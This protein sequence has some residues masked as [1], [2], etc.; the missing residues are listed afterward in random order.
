MLRRRLAFC[1]ALLLACLPGGVGAAGSSG[2]FSLDREAV[3]LRLATRDLRVEAPGFGGGLRRG[4]PAAERALRSPELRSRVAEVDLGQLEAARLDA[5]GR[6]PHRLNLNLFADAEFEAEFERSAATAS[7]Y[8]LTGRL[9][10]QPLSTVVLA[11]NGDWVAGT[12][13]SSGGRYAVRPLGGGVA[14]VRQL[15][16]SA[17][18]RC[19]VGAE[20]A[21]GSTGRPPPETSPPSGSALPKSAPLSEAFPEDDGSVID[22]LVVYPSFAR[23]SVG[24]HLAM[25]ARIDSDVALTNEIYRASGAVQRLNLVGAV[26]L[27]RRPGEGADRVMPDILDRLVDGSDG[28]MDEAHALRDAYAADMVLLHWGHLTGLG[29]GL[30][31]GGVSGVAFQMEDLSGGYERLAFSVANSF[32]FA[33]ELGHGMGLR[34]HRADDA[35]NTPFPY[36]HGHVVPD[37]SPGLPPERE[38]RGMFTIMAS[39]GSDLYD[40]PRFSNPN[41]RYP[42]GSGAVIGVPGDAPS[43]SADGP[44]DAVRS[45]NGTRRVVANFRR[46]A[47]RC[48]YELSAPEGELPASG[49]EFRIGVR[50]GTGCA[51]SAWSNDDFVSV[52]EGA[53]GVGDGEVVFGVSANGGW[54]REAAVFVAGEAYLAEQATAK[55]RRAP[56]PVCDRIP[57][58]RAAITEAAGKEACGEVAASDLASIRVLDLSR[59][60]WCMSAICTIEQEMRTALPMGSLDGLTGLVSLDLTIGHRLKALAPGL[61]DGLVRLARLD[62]SDNKLEALESGVFEGVPNLAYLNLDENWSLETIEP[63][64]FRGLANVD[65]LHLEEVGLTELREGAFEG[66]TNLRFLTVWDAAVAKTE[67]GAFDGLTNLQSL[68]LE[69]VGEAAEL[70]LGLFN[71]LDNLRYL[72]VGG[73]GGVAELPSGLFDGLD[74][75][76]WLALESF[77]GVGELPSGLFNGLDRLET[78]YLIDNHFETL[79]LGA[80]DGLSALT[81]LFLRNNDLQSLEPGVFSGL[82]ALETLFLD[83]NQLRSLDPD[84]FEG[85]SRLDWLNLSDNQFATLHPSLFRGLGNLTVLDLDGNK[86]ST[87]D[88]GLFDGQRDEY[89]R[90][91]MFRMNLSRNRLTRLE[92]GLLRGMEQLEYLELQDN[93]LAALPPRMFEGLYSLV[94]LDLSGNP[95]APFVFRPELVQVEGAAD[96]DGAAEVALELPQGAAFDL[97]VGLSASGGAL[98]ADEAGVLIGQT[99]GGTVAVRPDGAGSVAVRMTGV[100]EVPG[101]PCTEPVA[102]SRSSS[103]PCLKGVRT[104]LGASLVLRDFVLH[105]LSNQALAPGGAVRFDLGSA[106]PDFPDGTTYAVGVDAPAVAEA[107]LAE[108][109]LTVA[110][111]GRGAT[112]VSVTATAPDGRREVRSFTVAV[113]QAANSYWSG[114]RS[115]LLK[116]PSSVESDG[117]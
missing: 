52:A 86:L 10:D 117:S 83:G 47:V 109:L 33:H 18:G 43:D 59:A 78:L 65:E 110:A 54:E 56:P 79:A 50:A 112:T 80:F 88:A 5:E 36:S 95:G 105:G 64:A 6:H 48:R 97:R 25:R 94:G 111:T 91:F 34:H 100:S 22:L 85:L 7:G 35:E 77:D 42:E 107:A 72:G 68:A 2:L 27:P 57:G 60:F 108:G 92:P 114:W 44:A 37:F 98:S 63:G 3:P 23:R 66:L 71:G 74:N 99:R 39:G 116:S 96:S 24:G 38:G 58:V 1:A 51:W 28:Y 16:P 41:L 46:S 45:L 103:N 21:E 113:E 104:A 69:G 4:T 115:V 93:R 30:T 67:P 19:G 20:S 49:G 40:I 32:S 106:F 29:R 12:V 76:R 73:F 82:G 87:M 81:D 53:G 15:D 55:A 70:P 26:E 84:V 90:S 61:F 13:W 11:V 17:L 8:T 14:E 31:I 102:W 62:L 9:A 101:S 75:L 89:E